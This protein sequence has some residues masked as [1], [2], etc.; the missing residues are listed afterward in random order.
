MGKSKR[1]GY[2]PITLGGVDFTLRF[3]W[4]AF[5]VYEE[6]VGETIMRTIATGGLG[7]FRKLRE[8]LA[9]GLQHGGNDR[10]EVLQAI[11]NL[12]VAEA[13]YIAETV[14]DAVAES[15]PKRKAD[16]DDGEGESGE[17]AAP[18]RGNDEAT[19]STGS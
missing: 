19:T 2:F 7:G 11:A 13:F 10:K 9:A 1:R 16:D 8:A 14:S 4:N 17:A 15:L 6:A 3:D 5:A 18:V 12:D